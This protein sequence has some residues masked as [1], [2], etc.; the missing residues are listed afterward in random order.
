VM[1]THDSEVSQIASR[2]MVLDD[3]KILERDSN[4]SNG[5]SSSQHVQLTG[6]Q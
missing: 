4:H 2:Q 1:V 5:T 3:G 6:G